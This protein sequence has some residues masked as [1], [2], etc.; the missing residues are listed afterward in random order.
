VDDDGGSVEEPPASV[1]DGSVDLDEAP[2]ELLLAPSPL[3]AGLELIDVSAWRDDDGC[4]SVN[5]AY[6]G[7]GD[8]DA[9]LYLTFTPASCSHGEPDRIEDF[10]ADVTR[11][12]VRILADASF[13]AA[14]LTAV[15]DSLAPTTVDA[16]EG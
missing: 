9:Y 13:V 1:P 6:A 4:T 15:I 10:Y 16:L 2:P 3:P 8:D 12:D 7:A 14:E 11:G 5:L